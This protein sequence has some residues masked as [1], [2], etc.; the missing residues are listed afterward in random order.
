MKGTTRTA[1]A[2][3][4]ATLL[5]AC[6]TPQ[7]RAERF[8]VP[9]QESSALS[10]PSDLRGTYF[11]ESG[12]RLRYCAEPAPDVAMENL[13]KLVASLQGSVPNQA[14]AQAS[15]D[16]ETSAKVVQLA[17]RTQLVLIA[18]EMLYRAC[19]LSM[20]QP[21]IG[22]D[23]ALAMY[24]EVANLIKDMAAAERTLADAELNRS[25]ALLQSA[26]SVTDKIL[27]EDS[28]GSTDSPQ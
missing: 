28:G 4:T 23:T 8:T 10:M 12:G 16:A 20:N 14:S 9:D 17:G 5:S 7:Y 6:A 19:E 25:K 24:Q 18:R 21:E 26:G 27:K 3:L 22:K 11:L 13:Q 2:V 15:V 1:A